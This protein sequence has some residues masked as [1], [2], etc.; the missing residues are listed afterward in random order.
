[1]YENTLQKRLNLIVSFSHP[2]YN[3]SFYRNTFSSYF[4]IDQAFSILFLLKKRKEN[5]ERK[6]ILFHQFLLSPLCGRG[7]ERK[8]STENSKK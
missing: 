6:R 2:L 4:F 7:A 8:K 1:M 3:A 5:K